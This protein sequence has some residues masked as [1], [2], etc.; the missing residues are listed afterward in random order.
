M[1]ERIVG[2]L[3][4][5]PKASSY[6]IVSRQYNIPLNQ[7]CLYGRGRWEYGPGRGVGRHMKEVLMS[8]LGVTEFISAGEIEG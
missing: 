4:I 5:I 1:T 7:I 2:V 8:R 6:Q 3:D